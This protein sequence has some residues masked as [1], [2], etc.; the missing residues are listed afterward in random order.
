[1]LKSFSLLKQV[2]LDRKYFKTYILRKHAVKG[3]PEELML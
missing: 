3:R 2:A 1:M